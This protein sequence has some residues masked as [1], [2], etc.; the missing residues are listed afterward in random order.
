MLQISQGNENMLRLVYTQS[1]NL[2]VSLS[3]EIK[4]NFHFTVNKNTAETPFSQMKQSP[5]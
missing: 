4:S 5:Y 1:I 3:C 2:G